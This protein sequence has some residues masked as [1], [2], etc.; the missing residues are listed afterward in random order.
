MQSKHGYLSA[1]DWP[2]LPVFY[3]CTLF[4][5]ISVIYNYLLATVLRC[6]VPGL[7]YLRHCLV[8]CF[9]LPMERLAA[10][11]V[12]DWRRHPPWHA[13]KGNFFMMCGK[14]DLFKFGLLFTGH[15][16]CRVPKHQLDRNVS[17]RCRPA[18][19]NC[20]VWQKDAC[21][22]AGHNC[23]LGLWNRKVSFPVAIYVIFY[24]T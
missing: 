1:A 17:Q 6:N 18:G 15:V 14:F 4:W 11:P 10:H 23:Q 19:R 20:F 8:G 9:L 21:Q 7:R 16:L 24:R 2:L 3:Q 5:V 12:L 22:N 13:R